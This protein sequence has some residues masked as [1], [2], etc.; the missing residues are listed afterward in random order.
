MIARRREKP[1]ILLVEDNV[2][3][4]EA[5]AILLEESGY[6]VEEA[7]TGKEAIEKAESA[8]PAVIL[9][10]LGLPDQNGLAVTRQIK[11]NP[12]TR[13]SKV[14][15]ITGRALEVDERTCREAGCTGYLAKP[16]DTSILLKTIEGLVGT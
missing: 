2:T 12:L 1:V 8:E 6:R 9:M 3:I 16:V 11:A 13:S 7:A 4:R 15:A 14:I 10:D 5:F